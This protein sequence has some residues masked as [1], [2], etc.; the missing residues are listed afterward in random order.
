MRESIVKTCEGD[1][2]RRPTVTPFVFWADR[3]TIRKSMGYSPF[4]I[5]HGIEPTLPFDLTEMTF[6]LPKLDE[7][8]TEEE[9]LAIRA[10]QLE[11]C[12]AD[13]A[14]LHDHVLKS[15]YTSVA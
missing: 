8:L 3:V 5:A 11:K 1:I 4:F 10:R 2:S 12:D 14:T 7:P 15:R 6:L 13:L 9:L